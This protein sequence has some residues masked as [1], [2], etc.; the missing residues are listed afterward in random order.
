MA[1]L[2]SKRAESGYLGN[3][4]GSS[5]LRSISDLI[6]HKHSKSRRG[7]DEQSSL[8]E[9]ASMGS[10]SVPVNLAD[11]A[12]INSLIDA[13]FTWYHPSYPI[14][15]EKTFRHEYEHRQQIHPRSTW[16][17]I[18]F[19]VLAIGHWTVTEDAEQ[20]HYYTAARSRMSMRMLESGTLLAVQAFLLMG[21]YLQKRDRPNTGYNFVGIAFRMALGLGLHREPPSGTSTANTLLNERRRVVWWAVIVN[22]TPISLLQPNTQPLTQLLLHILAWH[23][24][25]M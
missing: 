10:P 25:G 1:S 21:N 24:S 23:P 17:S 3:T 5:L 14:L 22:W 6:P 13:Y 16:H 18:F 19:L 20:S 15:H 12:T 7:H 2:P 9:T 4:S 11:T 8:A